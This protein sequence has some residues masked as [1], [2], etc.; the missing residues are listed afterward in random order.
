MKGFYSSEAEIASADLKSC[1]ATEWIPAYAGMTGVE[2]GTIRS[3]LAGV[4]TRKT[5]L[6]RE[7]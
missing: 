2:E 3:L 6:G 4:P 1:L 7:K 5:P